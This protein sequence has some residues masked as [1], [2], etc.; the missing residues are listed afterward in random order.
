[1]LF[2]LRKLQ[3]DGI[4]WTNPPIRV[5]LFREEVL[6]E[7]NGEDHKADRK[8]DEN[9]SS[10]SAS[11]RCTA[12][13]Q[14]AR[15][16]LAADDDIGPSLPHLRANVPLSSTNCDDGGEEDDHVGALKRVTQLRWNGAQGEKGQ[17]CEDTSDQTDPE[18]SVRGE[19]R[20]TR[21]AESLEK[22]VTGI[23]ET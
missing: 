3:L 11:Q 16:F 14:N 9:Q 19:S 23:E 18:G 21:Y 8:A 10:Y 4:G 7:A 5:P 6:K 20:E 12:Y 2:L 13:P 1:M 17:R 22:G 15:K